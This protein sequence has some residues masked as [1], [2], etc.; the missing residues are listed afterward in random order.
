MKERYIILLLSIVASC[1][2]WAQSATDN[3]VKDIESIAQQQAT[4]T[5]AECDSV[6]R[7][8]VG[9]IPQD[10]LLTYAMHA[11]KILYPPYSTHNGRIAYRV[12]LERLLQ[13]G[14]DELVLL[15]YRYMYESLCHN[16]EGDEAADFVYYD[17]ND[18]EHSLHSLRGARTLVIFNDPECEDCAA[19]RRHIVAECELQGEVIDADTRV[20]VVYPDEPTDEW[21]EAIA[22][23]P[24]S[25]IVGYS[26]DV[27]DLYDLRTL[28]STYLLDNDHT[29]LLRDAHTYITDAQ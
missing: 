18:Q 21:R 5:I 6:A 19:L 23:Y 27:S 11:Q 28:P 10:E 1:G 17:V 9:A 15:R 4:F 7:E 16:N 24:D 2:V 13:S 25:W 29:I 26:P 8:W 3:I 20:L 22:H 14:G 12:L